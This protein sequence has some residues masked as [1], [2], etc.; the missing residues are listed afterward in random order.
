MEKMHIFILIIIYFIIFPLL[1]INLN[2]FVISKIF[3]ITLKVQGIGNH[4]ILYLGQLPVK[5]RLDN[6]HLP[7][8]VIINGI[9]RENINYTYYFNETENIVKIKYYSQE[10]VNNV[11]INKCFFYQC[12]EIT[13]ID[14]SEFDTS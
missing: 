9:P 8:E 7:D 2:I 1:H 10:D 5:C 14:L 11:A 13:E 6:I 3:N 4:N 12:T